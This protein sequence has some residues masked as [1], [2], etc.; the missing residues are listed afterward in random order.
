MERYENI[1]NMIAEQQKGK[2]GT[3]AWM[4]GEQLKEIASREPVSAELLEKDLA[5]P[6]MNLE[7]AADQIK[8]KADELHKKQKGNCV[9]VPPDVAEDVIRKFYG[10]PK[11][12]ETVYKPTGPQVLSL[13]DFL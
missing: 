13:A 3:P 1:C 7:K 9:C 11:R 12:G 2:E 8:K 10:L 5:V 4:V 6:E